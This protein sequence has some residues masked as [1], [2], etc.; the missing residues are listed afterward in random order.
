MADAYF[1][2][3]MKLTKEYISIPSLSRQEAELANHINRF[4]GDNGISSSIDEAGNVVGIIENG[5]GPTLVM[6]G[7]MDTVPP[8][9]QWKR[10]PYTPKTEGD[11]LYGLGSSDM[12]GSLAAL[13]ATAVA[14]KDAASEW[15]GRLV[16]TAVVN[17]EGGTKKPDNL[18]GTYYLCSDGFL[19]K[20]RADYAIVGETSVWKTG[21]LGLRIGHNGKFRFLVRVSGI[22]AHASR[23]DLG[24]N[25][26]YRAMDFVDALKNLYE[27]SGTKEIPHVTT[28]AAF[29][30]PLAV[31][32]IEGGRKLNQIPA[33][34]TVRIDRRL[35]YGEDIDAVRKQVSGLIA[36]IN[37]AHRETHRDL[38][39][40]GGY[41][42]TAEMH[43]FGMN[44]PAYMLPMEDPDVKRLFDVTLLAVREAT[45]NENP[46]VIYGTGYTDAELLYSMSSVPTI[47]IGAGEV[48]HCPDE[49]VR[50]SKLKEALASYMG[51]ALRL[52]SD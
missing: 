44:R 18:R 16:L 14:F 6:N 2:I 39:A 22:S 52:L 32:M 4:L 12:K 30:P 35:V 23:P 45:G 36:S 20:N 50:I 8:T 7:H 1:E 15:R 28:E 42:L 48:A 19:S 5:E 38:L 47:I 31:T 21:E 26:I 33:E 11:V 46:P 34:C 37:A 41:D 17:E 49:Y 43:E 40:A 24:V 9:P 27:S 25:A 3:M 10:D 51:T 29:K 13:T